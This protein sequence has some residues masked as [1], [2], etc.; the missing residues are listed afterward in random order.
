MSTAEES[1]PAEPGS[2]TPQGCCEAQMRAWC[3]TAEKC[4]RQEPVKC[5][6]IAFLMGLVVTVL[7]V[8]QILGALIRLAFG[9][10]RPALVVLGAVKVFEEI[11]KRRE[12]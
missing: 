12:P 11:E 8:G 6:T 5:A 2:E 3:A 7:P 9:L 1:K 4:A 10:I